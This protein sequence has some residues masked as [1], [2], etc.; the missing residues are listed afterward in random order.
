MEPQTINLITD[1]LVPSI[2]AAAGWLAGKRKR[3]ND[4]LK[5]MQDS[6]DILS[7]ENKRLLEDLT[8]VNR[9][10]VALRKENGELKY[11]VDQ[12]CKENSQLKDEVRDLR[13][14]ITQPKQ[15]RHKTAKEKTA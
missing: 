13:K 6:I 5:N 10:V 3:R 7:K 14:R 12:L 8:A 11:S 1:C 4:F 2:T 15:T 9:E